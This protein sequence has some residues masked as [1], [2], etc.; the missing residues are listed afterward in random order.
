MRNLLSVGVEE[1]YLV[2]GY[3]ASFIQKSIKQLFPD[4]RCSFIYNPKY[5][6]ENCIYSFYLARPYLL[7]A[8]TFRLVGDIVYSKHILK[9]LL[10]SRRPIVSAVKRK[11]KRST[12]EYCV[13]VDM[14]TH[15]ILQYGTDIP[16]SQSFG[17]AKGIEFI[18]SGQAELVRDAI[19]TVIKERGYS[20]FAEYAYQHM[21]NNGQSIY[22]EELLKDEYWFEL[23]TIEDYN[24]IKNNNILKHAI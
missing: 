12:N 13:K 14:R 4:I 9:R 22:Y 23:D 11:I 3:K 20:D 1:F 21:I 17:E 18:S 7:K 15:T 24:S 6:T 10:H 2:T 5:N 8:N 19:E 16:R